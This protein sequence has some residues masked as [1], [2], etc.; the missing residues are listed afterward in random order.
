MITDYI[1]VKWVS[2]FSGNPEM[3]KQTQNPGGF[4]SS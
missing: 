1:F 2:N 3:K 4:L